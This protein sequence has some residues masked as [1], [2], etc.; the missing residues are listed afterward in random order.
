MH[1]G[2]QPGAFA[3]GPDPAP[4]GSSQGGH[5]S[6]AP[7]RTSLRR[8]AWL[9]LAF[10]A[11]FLALIW[12][13]RPLVIALET[14]ARADFIYSIY[15][16]G[17][18]IFSLILSTVVPAAA[19]AGAVCLLISRFQISWAS[20]GSVSK[21]GVTVKRLGVAAAVCLILLY[22]VRHV[23]PDLF[24]NHAESA[25]AW[26]IFEWL[27]SPSTQVIVVVTITLLTAALVGRAILRSTALGNRAIS[28]STLP[29]PGA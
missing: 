8:S 3:G 27:V 20:Q 6:I 10:S 17:V 9:Y 25:L 1:E 29:A 15:S 28:S 24:L 23:L 11:I 26:A 7:S 4:T 21:L 13:I 19:A 12:V 16:I 2:N 14:R 5:T 18:Q 22:L